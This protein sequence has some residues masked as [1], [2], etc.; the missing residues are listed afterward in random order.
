MVVVLR[1]RPC[2]RSRPRSCR[3]GHRRWA[4]AVRHRG[5]RGPVGTVAVGRWAAGPR[6]RGA[7]VAASTR[8][9]VRG[10]GRGRGRRG[11]ELRAGARRLGREPDLLRRQRA[12]RV[13][14]PGGEHHAREGAEDT[15]GRVANGE[16]GQREGLRPVFGQRDGRRGATA[17]AVGEADVAAPARASAR[18]RSAGRGRCPAAPRGRRCRGGSARRPARAR[19][20]RRPGPR[21]GRRP[22]R[23]A[24]RA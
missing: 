19:P 21:R 17:V 9:R 4:A 3:R 8:A 12:G 24:G 7:G 15:R 14:D 5:R 16:G 2:P 20:G 18:A 11:S 1:R 13:G 10:P 6:A 23:G 22:P